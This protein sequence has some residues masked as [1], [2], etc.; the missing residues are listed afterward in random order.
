MVER[1][2]NFKESTAPNHK[3]FMEKILIIGSKGFIGRYL[4]TFL[5]GKGYIVKGADVVI[6]Y[7]NSEN[8][9]LIDTLNSDFDSILRKEE[10]DI[11]INCSG[12]ASVPDSITNPM[13]DYT[14]N[15]FNVF[16]ILEAI[17]SNQPS[18]R[19]VN[20]SSAAVYGNPE[21]LP[22]D[23]SSITKP[24]S[25][26]GVHKLHAEKLCR[27]FYEFYNIRTCSLRVFSVYGVG[28]QKQLFWD[29]HKKAVS[30]NP[31]TLYGTGNESR[32]FINVL[33]VAR[34]IE[35][36]SLSSGFDADIINIANGTEVSIK[37]AV[38]IFYSFFPFKINY[39]FSGDFRKGDPVNWLADI[40]KLRSFG[41]APTV[42]ITAGLHQYYDWVR[43][44]SEN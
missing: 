4:Y 14:L 22:V 11:C 21:R 43:L 15:T 35:L 26:Y 30:H 2:N 36:V 20:L 3:V 40:S 44:N 41:Y 8:Y 18:C 7:V 31:F 27:M 37:D 12:A 24:V 33:D 34:A 19:F 29:L 39:S 28:L 42:D 16:K 10:F 13:R 6:D 9:F 23:E 1:I 5:L 25:P 17:R 38:S 32:D